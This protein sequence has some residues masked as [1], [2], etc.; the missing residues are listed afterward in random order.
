MEFCVCQ[1]VLKGVAIWIVYVKFCGE[2][3]IETAYLNLYILKTVKR[4]KCFQFHNV[5]GFYSI[6]N[7][8]EFWEN[9]KCK[10]KCLVLNNKF[11]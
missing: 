9:I 2:N 1:S 5:N 10:G 4:I 8:T 3:G 11:Y 6:L 7:K